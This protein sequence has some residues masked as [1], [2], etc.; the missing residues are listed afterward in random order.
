[1][2]YNLRNLFRIC[3]ILCVTTVIGC[4]KDNPGSSSQA[5]S[6]ARDILSDSK[7]SNLIV[8]LH[9]TEE[10]AANP[11][12]LNNLK[13]FINSTCNKPGGVSYEEKVIAPFGKEQLTIADIR[14]YEKANRVKNPSGNTMV[15]FML[16][17]NTGY[18]EDSENSK[19]LGVAYGATSMCI[20][21]KTIYENSNGSIINPLPSR[22]KLETTVFN[23]EFGHLIG[24]VNNGTS[25]QTNHQ[26]R[27]HGAHC[28]ETSCLMFWQVETSANLQDLVDGGVPT[29]D[30]QCR[31]DIAAN[32]GKP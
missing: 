17:T 13:N 25:M 18:S 9:Y 30:S 14:A 31:Q 24:L 12:S 2:R 27:E 7:Y 5:G 26:D 1:M 19:V 22:E 29:L 10:F 8:E 21:E 3:L 28:D 4:K 11:N 16:L 20:F 32:G 6:I 23:H 15:I